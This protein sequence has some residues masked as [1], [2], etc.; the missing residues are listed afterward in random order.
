MGRALLGPG[1]RTSATSARS[2]WSERVGPTRAGPANLVHGRWTSVRRIGPDPVRR[3]HRSPKIWTTAHKD[4]PGLGHA[5]VAKSA[6]SAG[7]LGNSR[8]V[9]T[10]DLGRRRR[11]APAAADRPGGLGAQGS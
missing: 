10:R 8:F 11:W 3:V 9:R 6:S 2:P 4:R 1:G 5:G 7:T